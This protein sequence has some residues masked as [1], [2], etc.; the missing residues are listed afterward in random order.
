MDW[1]ETLGIGATCIG[2]AAMGLSAI[3]RYRED[4]I[5]KEYDFD[6]GSAQVEFTSNPFQRHLR[7]STNPYYIKLSQ[8]RGERDLEK[9]VRKGKTEG[10][11][12]FFPSEDMWFNTVYAWEETD[13]CVSASS[14]MFGPQDVGLDADSMIFY[15]THPASARRLVH[16]N[17]LERSERQLERMVAVHLSFPSS[18]D[19]YSFV[20][21]CRK[22]PQVDYEFRIA[23]PYG[24]TSFELSSSYNFSEDEYRRLRWNALEATW[25][26]ETPLDVQSQALNLMNSQLDGITFSFKSWEE[27]HKKEGLL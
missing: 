3:R 26:A 24:M 17:N 6:D 2:L 23:S 18:R 5:N 22:Y 11:W 9:L 8:E 12:I 7:L 19:L 10:S 15:H 21:T 1:Q 13:D 27:Y 16:E 20:E 14:L 4:Q 25:D